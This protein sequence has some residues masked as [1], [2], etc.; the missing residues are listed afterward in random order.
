MII[1]DVDG[2]SVDAVYNTF[3]GDNVEG[4][5]YNWAANGMSGSVHFQMGNPKKT[6]LNGLTTEA[7][8]AI[9]IHRT[10]VVDSKVP[11]RENKT[12]INFMERALET[13]ESRKRDRIARKVYGE[14]K[15]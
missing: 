9:L 11:C 3:D 8:L 4:Y 5:R 10:E 7:I 6:G 13:L 14:Q 2:V 15:Q 1:Y 12:A